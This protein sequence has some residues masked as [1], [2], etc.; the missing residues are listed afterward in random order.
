MSPNV[1]QSLPLY[2]PQESGHSL[3]SNIFHMFYRNLRCSLFLRAVA[4]K[5]VIITALV[6]FVTTALRF[7]NPEFQWF[8]SLMSIKI[9]LLRDKAIF[10]A[11]TNVKPDMTTSSSSLTPQSFIM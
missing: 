1:P 4:S 9:G 6:R 8:K 3:Q 10:A 2:Q 5:W 7:S 11:A